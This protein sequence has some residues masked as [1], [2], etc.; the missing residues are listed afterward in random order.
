MTGPSKKQELARNRNFM[1]MQ[2]YGMQ[3]NLRRLILANYT[4]G[5]E[6]NHLGRALKAISDA[7]TR[8]ELDSKNFGI[9]IK[10]RRR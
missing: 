5:M 7:I 4:S 9:I 6:A 3:T 8:K 1:Y 10:K 2:L